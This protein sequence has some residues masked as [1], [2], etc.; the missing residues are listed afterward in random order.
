MKDLAV[1]FALGYVVG[2]F[3]HYMIAQKYLRRIR[4]IIKK[5]EQD[6]RN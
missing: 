3:I 1:G 4:K 6:G 5:E 2:T